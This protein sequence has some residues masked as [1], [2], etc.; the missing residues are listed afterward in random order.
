[1]KLPLLLAVAMLMLAADAHAQVCR[2]GDPPN[3]CVIEPSAVNGED[4]SPYCFVPTLP[5]GDYDTLYTV[6]SVVGSECHSFATYLRFTLPA[7]LLDPGETVTNALLVVRYNFGF[8]YGQGPNT[9]PHAPVT[10][11][12]HRVLAPWSESLMSWESKASYS[13]L[14]A[15]QKT[16][17]TQP[18][19]ISFNVT[20]LVRG[21]AHGTLPNYGFALTSPDSHTMGMYSW[22]T[23]VPAS[24]KN[25]LYI[26]IGNGAPPAVP[27]MPAWITALFVIGVAT[28]LALRMPRTRGR[29]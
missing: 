26:F 27:I 24:E 8:E 11:N 19:D 3:V 13:A 17:I 22:E 28:L 9:N 29:F 16:G 15:A 2:A 7:N 21:W 4:T 12:V 20:T 23:D 6:T 1:M 5:R 14:P 18:G 25:A 10:M